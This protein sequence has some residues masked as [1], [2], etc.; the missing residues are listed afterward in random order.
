MDR[1]KIEEGVKLILEGIGVDINDENFKDTPRRFADFLEELLEP[2]ITEDDYVTF[3]SSGN[4]VIVKGIKVY[5]LC[6]HHLLPVIYEVSVAYIPRGK[7]VGLSK[8]ARLAMTLGG[9]L[10]LQEDYTEKLA[11][12][13]QMLVESDDVMV[14][15]RGKHFCMVMRGVKQSD[16][17]VITSAVRGKFV[18]L[19]LRSET[20][21]LMGWSK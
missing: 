21:K 12:E 19:E 8:I 20:L 11:D 3:T 18:E 17:E 2:K 10:M 14:V 15:V 4:L 5:S 9:K 6:P 16:A 1:R 7:V 13:L